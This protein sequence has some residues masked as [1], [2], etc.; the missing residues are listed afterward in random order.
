MK[1]FLILLS[2]FFCSFA[3]AVQESPNWQSV[4]KVFDRKGILQGGVFKVTFPRSDLRV[5]IGEVSIEP[6]LALTSWIA[7][8][9]MGNNAMMM[10]DLVLLDREIDPVISK[11]VSNGIEITALHNH[12]VNESP[13][14]MY[15]HFSGEGDPVKLAQTMKSAL[16]ETNTPLT[17]PKAKTEQS[18]PNINWSKVISILGKTGKQ[19]GNLLK[20][21][22]P[23]AETI[24]ENGM[25]IPPSMGMAAPINFQMVGE[26]AAAYGDFVLLG[27]EVNPVVKALTKHGIVVTAVHNHMLFESPRLFFLHFW[28]FD[29]PEKLANGL[30]AALEKTNSVKG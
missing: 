10:G 2:L 13:S 9:Q 12:L 22:F 8:K 7:F 20:Y 5:K 6:R 4:E 16:A 17:T 26:K 3:V 28:G 23:R 19:E 21:S 30:K 18:S 14:V 1:Q 25:D 29:A 11:L 15:M 24:T 27:S